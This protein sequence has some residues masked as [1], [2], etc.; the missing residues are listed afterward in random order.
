MDVFDLLAGSA[1]TNN[2]ECIFADEEDE[3]LIPKPLPVLPGAELVVR[4]DSSFMVQTVLLSDVQDQDL[5]EQRFN[6]NNHHE[7]APF[8]S[9]G[10][11]SV[12]VDSAW[13]ASLSLDLQAEIERVIVVEQVSKVGVP[14]RAEI[15][16]EVACNEVYQAYTDCFSFARWQTLKQH[17]VLVPL[18]KKDRLA[19]ES[20]ARRHVLGGS[21]L[22][23]ADLMETVGATLL[24][25]LQAAIE[26]VG[27]RA[28]AKTA[29]KSAKNDLLLRPHETPASI[30]QELTQSKDVLQQSLGRGGTG[31]RRT[32]RYLV[33]QPWDDVVEAANEFRV[34]IIDRQVAGITQQLWAR[35]VGHTEA[36]AAAAVQ[37]LLR[38]WYHVLLPVSPYA[39]C[40]LDAYVEGNVAHLIEV[41]PCGFW[42]SSGSG[43][44]HWLIDRELLLGGGPLPVRVVVLEPHASTIEARAGL[45]SLSY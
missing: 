38:L 39:D 3:N 36:S 10:D 1:A 41:N 37:P 31:K 16:S 21:S 13:W 23:S 25:D 12:Q 17:T 18:L 15:L 24:G 35:F 9:G 22:Q 26:S 7:W 40:V 28:F 4:D 30:L 45:T 32:A 19:L 33:V 27:G 43:L 5:Q 6:S 2:S 11:F 20:L 42:G 14:H 34:I 29:E 8:R 44:F